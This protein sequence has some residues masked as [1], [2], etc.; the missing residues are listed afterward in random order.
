[1]SMGASEQL[2]NDTLILF[3]RNPQFLADNIERIPAEFFELHPLYSK[4]HPAI[5]LYVKEHDLAPPASTIK[6]WV[7]EGRDGNGG[8]GTLTPVEIQEGESFFREAAS[9]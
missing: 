2:L 4:I 9:G 5:A 1:M 3:L 8:G 7:L 6:Q